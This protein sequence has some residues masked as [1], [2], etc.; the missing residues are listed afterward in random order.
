MKIINNGKRVINHIERLVQRFPYIPKKITEGGKDRTITIT[1]KEINSILGKKKKK[2]DY[3]LLT[4][5]LRRFGIFLDI[6]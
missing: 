6:K 5:I 3:K 2:R 4:D 1:L